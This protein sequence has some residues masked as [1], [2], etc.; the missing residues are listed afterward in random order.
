[1]R[2]YL[3]AAPI[4]YLVEQMQPFAS[5]VRRRLASPGLVLV[6]SEL[7]RLECR[8]LPV[9]N[10]NSILLQDFDDY[11]VN[12]IAELVPLT[13]TVVDCATEIR[14]Q[15]NFKTPDAVH[16]AAAVIANCDV[17]LTNDYRLSRFTGLTIEVI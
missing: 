2:Y 16:L 3:D 14:A 10:S 1:M 4:I 12:T 6:T 11:F 17:F 15:F 13:R 8:V 9:R 7:A 5:A